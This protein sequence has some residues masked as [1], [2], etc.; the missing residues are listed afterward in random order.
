MKVAVIGVGHLG[1]HHARLYAEMPAVELVGIVDILPDRAAEIAQ[2]HR[3]QA[4]SD[5]REL[6]GKVNAVSLAVPTTEHARIGTELLRNGIDVLV[7]KPIADT[8]DGAQ[9]LIETAAQHD[10]I[11]QTG[12][13]E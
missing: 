6:F 7:E 4:L 3:T 13:V 2:S 5:Y 1:K 10:R 11:L 12:H 9:A 8:I